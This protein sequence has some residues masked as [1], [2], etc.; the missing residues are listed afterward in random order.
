M[1]YSLNVLPLSMLA[2]SHAIAGDR[3]VFLL[4]KTFGDALL[5][6]NSSSNVSYSSSKFEVI[7][8]TEIIGS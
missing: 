3:M 8:P 1:G 4:A 5:T 7:S 6:L 2:F